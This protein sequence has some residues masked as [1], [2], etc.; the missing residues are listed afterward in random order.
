[1]KQIEMGK[2]DPACLLTDVLPR[3]VKVHSVEHATS[4]S[5]SDDISAERTQLPRSP[6]RAAGEILNA[7][8]RRWPS[9]YY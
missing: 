1:M 9:R 4:R 7:A 8:E 6:T 3:L 5:G 2:F